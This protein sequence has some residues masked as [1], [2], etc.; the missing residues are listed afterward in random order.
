M[1]DYVHGTVHEVSPAAL[2][3]RRALRTATAEG[4]TDTVHFLIEQWGAD[5]HARSDAPFR[6]AVMQNDVALVKILLDSVCG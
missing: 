1:H 3:T 4:D 6:M 2:M 5:V